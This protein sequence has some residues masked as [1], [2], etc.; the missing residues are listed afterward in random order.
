MLQ[1]STPLLNKAVFSLRTNAPIANIASVIVNPNNLKIEGFYCVDRYSHNQLVLLTQDIRDMT[2]GSYIV[3]DH[4]VLV[5]AN[6][7][8]R[9]KTILALNFNIIGKQVVTLSKEKVGKV[10]DYAVDVS[11]M[12]IQKIY[13]SQSLIKSFTGGNLSIDRSQIIEITP[14]SIVISEL[15][16]KSRSGAVVPAPTAL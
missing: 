7:L 8:V 16:N 14:N 12:Y 13:V 10:N 6:E 11:S 5:E 1:L 4:D 9:L 15:L 3:N 2:P